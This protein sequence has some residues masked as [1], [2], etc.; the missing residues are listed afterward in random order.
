[1]ITADGKYWDAVYAGLDHIVVAGN[2]GDLTIIETSSAN[3][4]KCVKREA[5]LRW[6]DT[7]WTHAPQIV[8]HMTICT[9]QVLALTYD[10]E[11]DSVVIGIA[12]SCK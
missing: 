7:L 12:S 4:C 9:G 6:S 10:G 2:D 11:D 3:V 8:Q 1:L 5:L